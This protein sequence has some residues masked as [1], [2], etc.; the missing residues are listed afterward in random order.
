MQYYCF[1][2][3]DASRELCTIATPFGLYHSRCLPMGV[4]RSPDIAQEIMERVLSSIMEEIECDI[5]DIATFSNDWESH[6]TLL[7]KL[8]TK[9][10]NAG[11]TVNPLTCKW[12]VQETDFLGHWLNLTGIKTWEKNIGGILDMKAPTNIKQIRAFLGMVGYYRDMWPRHSHILAPLT[13]LKGKKAFV[14]EDKHQ[15][16]FEQ[17]KALIAM[18][19]LLAYPNHNKLFDI[20]TDA[21]G[22]QLGAV[23]KQDNRPVAYYTRKLNSVQKYYNTIKKELLS[24]VETLKEFRSMLLGAPITIYTD[25]KNLTHNLSSFS[26]QRVLRWHLLLEEF[27][28]NYKYKEGSQNLVADVLSRVPTSRLVREKTAGPGEKNLISQPNQPQEPYEDNQA[29]IT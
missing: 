6:K 29:C 20:E 22:Y 16:A 14:W 17:M 10:Q 28:C 13:E 26:T 9:L 18:N 11:F 23:I 19:A 4:N 15:Q 8:L 5:S 24:I 27:G 12:A 7:N 21:S 2:L 3:D 1:E 25:H